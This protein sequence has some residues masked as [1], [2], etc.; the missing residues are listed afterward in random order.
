MALTLNNL[1]LALDLQKPVS[2]IEQADKSDDDPI[3]K[4]ER[5]QAVV[6]PKTDKDTILPSAEVLGG[7]SWVVYPIVPNANIEEGD[8]VV[9]ID[10]G[11]RLNITRANRVEGILVGDIQWL[12]TEELL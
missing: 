6:L 11:L 3:I 1:P 12:D 4:V 2:V 9:V 10:E 7:K 5:M 8:V